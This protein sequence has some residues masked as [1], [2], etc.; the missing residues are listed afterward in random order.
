M[1]D[2][3]LIE[4]AFQN[5]N[6]DDLSVQPEDRM[7]F[8]SIGPY[9]YTADRLKENDLRNNAYPF[10]YIFSSLEMVKHAIN[11]RFNIFLDKKY[12]KYISES[13]TQHLFYSKFI[14]TEILR[15]LHIASNL[16]D[17]ANNLTNREIFLHHNLFDDEIYSSFVNRCNRLLNLIYNNNKIVFVYCNCYTNDFNDILDFYNNFSNNKNIYVVGIF[18]NSNDK[19][20]LYENTNC[21]IY[22]NYDKKFIFD[23]IKSTFYTKLDFH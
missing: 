12:Y 14:D 15:K 6:N 7:E 22:Q 11:D 21:K 8:I 23:E 1:E 5:D 10:D 20:I 2:K 13:C 17:I 18:E 3:K 4:T 9:C 19:K 16:P